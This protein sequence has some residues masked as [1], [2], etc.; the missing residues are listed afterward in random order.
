[1][2]P[3]TSTL[4]A[5]LVKKDVKPTLKAT[6]KLQGLRPGFIVT[7]IHCSVQWGTETIINNSGIAVTMPLAYADTTYKILITHNNG[8]LSSSV[9]PLSVGY[10]N[11]TYFYVS[12][13]IG[14]N[15][16]FFWV[17]VGK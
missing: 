17:T 10:I 4:S 2:L 8:I 6:G 9:V 5:Y 12:N 11:P 16:N 1:M 13:N 3:P 14:E 7:F 15:P